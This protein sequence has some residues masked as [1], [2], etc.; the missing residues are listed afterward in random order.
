MA[1]SMEEYDPAKIPLFARVNRTEL[2]N[3]IRFALAQSEVVRFS[4][5]KKGWFVWTGK[6][7]DESDG[8]YVTNA[9]KSIGKSIVAE[10]DEITEEKSSAAHRKW[11]LRSEARSTIS[12]SLFL[13]QSE[14][15]I[16]I[17]LEQLDSEA[18]D[19]LFNAANVTLDL[20]NGGKYGHKKDDYITKISP[21]V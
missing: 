18:T 8:S 16:P 12:N 15:G 3:A 10:A 6:V 14:D 9:M 19:F 17:K 20:R 11:G 21:V 4:Y 7:W 2:G 5:E 13:A 1:F